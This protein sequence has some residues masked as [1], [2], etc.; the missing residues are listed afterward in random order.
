MES[1]IPMDRLLCGDV[2]FGK[3]ELAIR[4]S[5]KAV[6]S[7][8]QVAIL[9]PT[10]VLADQ[11]YETFR[12][13]LGQFPVNIKCL[14]RLKTIKESNEIK[15]QLKAGQIDICIGTHKLLQ[16]AIDFKD[17]GLFIIDEEHKFGVKQKEFL[18]SMRLNLDMLSLSA[19]PIP[20]T[21]NLAL[22]GVRD[23]SMIETA[24]LDRS[25]L[26]Y[27]SPSPRDRG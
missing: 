9:V 4:A 27:T 16:N 6:Q 11:H 8:K 23:L 15:K 7:G 22:S 24:P 3:T 13:R 2:G 17:L 21:M 14:S 1:S 10:T 5:F 18:K 20:R 19:T 12:A 26:L 25:C